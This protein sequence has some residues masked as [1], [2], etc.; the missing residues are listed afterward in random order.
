MAES[1]TIWRQLPRI[2]SKTSQTDLGYLPGS[3]WPTPLPTPPS[4]RV[5]LNKPQSPRLELLPLPFF[6]YNLYILS[7][8]LKRKGRI[9]DLPIA[10]YFSKKKVREAWPH[11]LNVF[12]FRLVFIWCRDKLSARVVPAKTYITFNCFISKTISYY[13]NNLNNNV[14]KSK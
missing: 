7:E 10:F 4:R 9:Q 6:C 3:S 2:F 12:L 14:E 1:S 11:L 8:T 13:L 5:L